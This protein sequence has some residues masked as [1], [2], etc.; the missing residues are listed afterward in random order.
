MMKL[1]ETLEQEENFSGLDI[2]VKRRF[3]KL[4]CIVYRR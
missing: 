2:S 3:G 1:E 4:K